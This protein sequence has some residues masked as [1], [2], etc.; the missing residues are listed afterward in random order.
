MNDHRLV[1]L[2]KDIDLDKGN[3]FIVLQQRGSHT[4]YGEYLSE[5]EKFL[6]MEPH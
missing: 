4:N 1:P 2:L 5:D 6:K 3:N